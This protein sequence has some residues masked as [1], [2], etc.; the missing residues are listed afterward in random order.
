MFLI[1]HPSKGLDFILYAFKMFILQ[2]KQLKVTENDNNG[3]ICLAEASPVT[4][5]S[6]FQGLAVKT[7]P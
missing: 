7:I 2:L 6:C 5:S 1:Q 3:F 4:I